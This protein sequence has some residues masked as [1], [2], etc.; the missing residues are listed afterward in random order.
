MSATTY[1]P[2]FTELILRALKESKDRLRIL[3]LIKIIHLAAIRGAERQ[4][5]QQLRATL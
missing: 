1:P 5:Y 4:G 2:V 3:I